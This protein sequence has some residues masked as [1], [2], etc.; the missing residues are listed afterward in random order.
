MPIELYRKLQ[1]YG[2]C[3]INIQ[4]D[5]P[6]GPVV[7]N[8]PSSAGDEGSIPG[9]ETINEILHVAGQVSPCATATEPV[10][11]RIEAGTPQRKILCT[12][13]KTR[14]SQINK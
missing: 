13:S 8:S 2:S 10:P 5:F 4:R 11:Q 14:R 1:T 12:A 7:K 3:S 6:G 9:W